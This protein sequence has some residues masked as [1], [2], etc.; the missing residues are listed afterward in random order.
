MPSAS[1]LEDALRGAGLRVTSPRVAVLAAVH[2]HPHL[3][4]RM[5]SA[6]GDVDNVV[7]STA[8]RTPADDAG[9]ELERT[10][11]VF[12]RLCHSCLSALNAE[13]RTHG[14]EKGPT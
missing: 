11:I 9:L 2:E 3:V 10:E 14:P 4:C 5:C 12:W 13:R 7:G 6:V 1:D 8:C